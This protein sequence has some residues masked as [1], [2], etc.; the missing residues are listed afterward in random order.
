MRYA[1]FLVKKDTDMIKT[2]FLAVWI[3]SGL[4]YLPFPTLDACNTAK[5]A[6]DYRIVIE[7]TCAEANLIIENE[8]GSVAPERSPMPRPRPRLYRAERWTSL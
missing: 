2:Y 3:G 1:F 5:K 7:A 8:E 4:F 6:L